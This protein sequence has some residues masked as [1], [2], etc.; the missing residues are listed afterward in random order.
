MS[1]QADISKVL[2]ELRERLVI[3]TSI[4]VE[5]I[6]IPGGPQEHY[7]TIIEEAYAM[8]GPIETQI[9]ELRAEFEYQHQRLDA[10]RDTALAK[11][12][13]ESISGDEPGTF[14]QG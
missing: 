6:L 14:A 3:L 13:Q 10:A 9:D 7:H 4:N 2:E 5:N 11:V 8:L 1:D 12:T